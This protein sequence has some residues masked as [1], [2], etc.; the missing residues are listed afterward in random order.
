[1]RVATVYDSLADR[2]G[3]PETVLV[4]DVKGDDVG[5]SVAEAVSSVVVPLL[6]GVDGKAN[7]TGTINQLYLN[8]TNKFI[9]F[10]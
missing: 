8:R 5:G 3:E 6:E 7:G 4:G 1:M 10:R 9:R 2:T